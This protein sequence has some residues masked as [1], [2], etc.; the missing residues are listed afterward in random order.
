MVPMSGG[1]PTTLF[2]GV[3]VSGAVAVD[4]ANVYFTDCGSSCATAIVA[5]AIPLD[6]GTVTTI[7]SLAANAAPGDI[8]VDGANVYFTAYEYGDGQVGR[9]PLDG[10]ATATLASGQTDTFD[11]T[12]DATNVYFTN[13]TTHGS[14]VMVPVVGGTPTTLVTNQFSPTAIAVDSTSVYW[15]T[16]ACAIA[17]AGACG[18]VQKMALDGGAANV[19]ASGTL[20]PTAMAIDANYL[21]WT[22]GNNGLGTVQSVPIGGGAVTILAA[23]QNTPAYIALD[24]TGLY[25]TAS[26]SGNVMRLVRP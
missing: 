2:N 17:D 26:G 12:T 3:Q 22:D 24:A 1:T 6:G 5:K 15:S 11:L 20:Q 25:W 18:V 14:V 21:Y 4:S 9:A 10:G 23:V 19:L 8:R 16:A 7:G 13:A